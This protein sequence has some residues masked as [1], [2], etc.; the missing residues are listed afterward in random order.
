[1][2]NPSHTAE[3][4]RDP[5]FSD[6]LPYVNLAANPARVRPRT[7]IDCG[8]GFERTREGRRRW[9]ISAQVSN[10][11]NRTA[12]YNFQSVFVGTRVVQPVTVGLRFRAYF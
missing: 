7:V 1:M 4:A 2:A 10:L 5:D 8:A 3:V 12:L 9:D 11:T 6:L